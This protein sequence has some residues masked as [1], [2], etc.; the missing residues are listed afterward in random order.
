[1]SGAS[2]KEEIKTEFVAMAQQVSNRN[3]HLRESAW[4]ML[5]QPEVYKPLAIMISFF[6]FQQFSGIFVVIVYAA[7]FVKETG[8]SF[9][10][11]L[12]TVL[13]GSIR[14]I[15]TV[16]VGYLLDTAG[17]KPPTIISGIGMTMCMFGLAAYVKFPVAANLDWLPVLLILMYI[18]TSTLG[19]L[20]IPFTMLAEMFPQKVR[21]LA[22]GITIFSAYSMSFVCIKLYPK[23]VELMGTDNVVIF[24]GVVSFVGIFYAWFVLPETKG[25]SLQDI[26]DYFKRTSVRLAS[27]NHVERQALK[28]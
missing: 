24:Y 26:E 28:V 27:G 21:G 10:P 23:M 2:N 22:S 25:K 11:L 20:T 6:A 4:E 18:F 5:Q 13:I 14:I 3:T 17:R 7:K 1:L 15:A 19:F 8:I 16:F 9:D 12:C